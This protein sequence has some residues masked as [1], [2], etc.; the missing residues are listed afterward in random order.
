MISPIIL[1]SQSLRFTFKEKVSSNVVGYIDD[2]DDVHILPATLNSRSAIFDVPIYLCVKTP[3]T[4]D[5]DL[6]YSRVSW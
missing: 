3:A 1:M 6:R 5:K 4:L 2:L